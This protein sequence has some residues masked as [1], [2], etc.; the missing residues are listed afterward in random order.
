MSALMSM[1]PQ[2]A[3]LA[4]TGQV[5]ACQDVKINTIIAVKAPFGSELEMPDSD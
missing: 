4:E 3:I 2:N 1:A 5:V